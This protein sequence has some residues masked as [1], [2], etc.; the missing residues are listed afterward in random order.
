MF[1]KKKRHTQQREASIKFPEGEIWDDHGSFQGGCE[2]D[3]V[4][5]S[6]VET[7]YEKKTDV[8]QAKAKRQTMECMS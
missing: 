8:S 5:E 1:K 6:S 3:S 4:F 7:G 2:I